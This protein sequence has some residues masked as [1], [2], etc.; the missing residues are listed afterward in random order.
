VWQKRNRARAA[1]EKTVTETALQEIM[2]CT[3]LRMRRAT[4]R[5]TQFY[6]R[7]LEPAGL[8]VNQFGLLGYLYGTSAAAR[9]DGPSLGTVAN[10]LGMDP[11]TLNRNLKPLEVKGL[12]RSAQNPSD[13]RVRIV[14]ITEKGKRALLRAMAFW[15]DAQAAVD[16]S[17]GPKPKALLNELLDRSATRLHAAE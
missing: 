16:K 10:W 7:A 3:C 2:G 12:V 1:D 4:R 15:R 13:A 8:T 5:V 9:A 17:L 6:D 11:T 14:R